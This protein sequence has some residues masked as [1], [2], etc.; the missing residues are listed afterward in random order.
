MGV[1]G[2][3]EVES[4]KKEEEQIQCPRC[5]SEDIRFED[6][7]VGFGGPI[8]LRIRCL[9]CNRVGEATS[10]GRGWEADWGEEK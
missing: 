1:G 9:P 5:G 10:T 8:T 7:M 2:R 4:D 3:A 6:M